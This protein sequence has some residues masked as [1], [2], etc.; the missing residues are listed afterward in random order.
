MFL[1][2]TVDLSAC[3]TQ[4]TVL[5]FRFH[6]KGVRFHRHEPV[7]EIA[8]SPAETGRLCGNEVERRI[9]VKVRRPANEC[10]HVARKRLYGVP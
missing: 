7:G 8:L 6:R 1:P 2:A 10:R 9:T 4:V 3:V 5:P